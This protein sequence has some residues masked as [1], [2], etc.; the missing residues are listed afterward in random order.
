MINKFDASK[1]DDIME[2]WLETNIEAHRFTPKEYWIENFDM[3]KKMLPYSDVY[4]YED[5][6]IIKGFIGVVEQNYIAGLFVK[7]EHQREGIGQKLIEYCKSKYP[8]L[9]LDVFKKNEK[10]V[11][12]YLKNDFIVVDEQI[13]KD[14]KEI[15]YTMSFGKK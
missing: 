14:I 6:N 9:V 4:V 7:K 5:G 15:E 3:V 13:H 2:I 11:R 12:F 10:A 8:Y 1:L